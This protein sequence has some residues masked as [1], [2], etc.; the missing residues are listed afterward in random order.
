[1]KTC[2]LRTNS[3]FDAP[4]AWLELS[5][6]NKRAVLRPTKVR[7]A[8]RGG[9]YVLSFVPA[10]HILDGIH[11]GRISV[12]VAI[13]VK[14]LLILFDCFGFDDRVVAF[15]VVVPAKPQLDL[16]LGPRE[17]LHQNLLARYFRNVDCHLCLHRWDLCK[18]E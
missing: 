6:R 4:I 3:C 12:F 5:R 2:D 7:E 9:G 18:Q 14:L 17:L 8:T 15:A 11:D 1:M 16:P 10:E 13:A